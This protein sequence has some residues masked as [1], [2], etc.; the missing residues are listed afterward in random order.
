M[1]CYNSCVPKMRSNARTLARHGV[2][3]LLVKALDMHL[4]QDTELPTNEDLW[5][6]RSRE[7]RLILNC[8][9]LQL[10]FDETP[11]DLGQES[12]GMCLVSLLFEATKLCSDTN[13]HAIPIKKVILLLLL[14]LQRLLDVP[15]DML[16][17]ADVAPDT[18][19]EEV[20]LKMPRLKE[21]QPFT[22]LHLH[23]QSLMR[24]YWRCGCPAAIQEGLRII[25][26]YKDDF[27]LNYPFH[28]SEIRFMQKMDFMH[29]AYIRYQHLQGLADTGKQD[30][31]ASGTSVEWSGDY[32]L[33][34]LASDERLQ[35]G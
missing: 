28:P 23:E 7:M 12:L 24:K 22:G 26:E 33:Q 34:K 27:L 14:V 20:P 35:L 21:F 29:D 5:V 10:L 6:Q 11:L 16:S 30:A 4:C 19:V 2:L 17:P 13:L 25:G 9:Y 18:S 15:D 8:I 31:Q 1:S 32:W 3:S